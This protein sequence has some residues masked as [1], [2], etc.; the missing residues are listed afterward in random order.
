VKEK[1][2]EVREL[3]QKINSRKKEID[4]IQAKLDK[5]EEE[6]KL[7]QK[8]KNQ[9]GEADD[10]ESEE[11]IIDEEELRLLKELKDLKREYRDH[12]G[13]LKSNKQ[14]LSH[15]QLNIDTSKEQLISQFELWYSQEFAKSENL[16]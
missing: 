13:L 15:L 7:T 9:F 8:A 2:E 4:V 11:V 14:E 5:K 3:T 10:Q 16:G 12:Y 6:R 1:R